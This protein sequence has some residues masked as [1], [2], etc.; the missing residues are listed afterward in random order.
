M[1]AALGVSPGPSSHLHQVWSH[2]TP[3]AQHM[4]QGPGLAPHNPQHGIPQAEQVQGTFAVLGRFYFSYKEGK[5]TKAW[6]QKWRDLLK[7]R[8]RMKSKK[9][10][11]LSY[12]TQCELTKRGPTLCSRTAWGSLSFLDHH[13]PKAFPKQYIPCFVIG[14]RVP[15]KAYTRGLESTLG[16]IGSLVGVWWFSDQA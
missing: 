13:V 9:L 10:G 11:L 4:Q 2:Q 16:N 8:E 12:P 3:A 5:T 14:D 1:A 15:P 7:S 6:S